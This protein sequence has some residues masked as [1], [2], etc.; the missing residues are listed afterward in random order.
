MLP[1]SVP[2]QSNEAANT[3]LTP[4]QMQTGSLLLR[5]K[6]GYVVATRMNTDIEAQVSGL[7]ARVKVRQSFRNDGQEWVEGVYVF[8]LPDT[9]A[10]DGLR[11]HIGER[12]R[13]GWKAYMYFHCPIPRRSTGFACISANE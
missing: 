6:S 13:S 1:Y 3:D 10:V 4:D 2:A 5:M 8:P 9:A 7:V 12:I 11:M